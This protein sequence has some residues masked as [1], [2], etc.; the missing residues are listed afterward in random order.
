MSGSFPLFRPL[1]VASL[2]LGA[3]A[4][5]FSEVTTPANGEV[6]SLTPDQKAMLNAQ[7]TE[8]KSDALARGRIERGV[9]GEVGAFIG[10]GGARG[11][12][13][14][15]AIPIGD[16]GGALISFESSRFGR[17]R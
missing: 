11:V 1:I 7:G 13:G 5:A 6:F 17:L 14:T 8:E 12:F 16:T 15:A 9:H 4:P 10:T 2:C 3:A